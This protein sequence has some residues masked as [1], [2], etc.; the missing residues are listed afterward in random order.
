MKHSA[1]LLILLTLTFLWSCISSRSSL[2]FDPRS[3]DEYAFGLPEYY[4]LGADEEHVLWAT[5]YY[6]HYAEATTANGHALLDTSGRSLGVSL[7]AYDWCHGS[8][9]G[10]VLVKDTSGALRTYN[11]AGRGREIQV[12]CAPFFKSAL[13]KPEAI[14]RTR[15]TYARGE[16]G[17]GVHGFVLVPFRT[18]AVDTTLYP[19]GSVL[20]IPALRGQ[21]IQLP[22]GK[23][24][25]HDGYV[26]AGD[27]GGA[28]KGNHI[29][30]FTGVYRKNPFPTV[31][32]S[33][34]S[35]TFSAFTVRDTRIIELLYT[36]HRFTL[37]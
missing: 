24:L 17:D 12:D 36:L 10:T 26:F 37:R 25:L 23:T 30:V 32:R 20:Y 2:V 22:S 3:L 35:A 11:Y 15:F 9:E 14:G 8:L 27:I 29:D 19:I 28:I 13:I 34:S 31:I 18:I 1:T 33:T 6:V 4:Q 7:S 21:A 5:Q 16:F